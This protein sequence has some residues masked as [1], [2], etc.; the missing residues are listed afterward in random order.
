ALDRIAARLAAPFVAGEIGG[1]LLGGE[2]LEGDDRAGEAM[3]G[4][5][6]AVDQGDRAKDAVAAARQQFQALA[7]LFFTFRLGEN[8]A[9][10]G[11][12]DVGGE[13]QR[14]W[15]GGRRRLR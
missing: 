7:A 8:P 11:D 3:A 15:R 14:A 4:L 2:A 1:D 10:G 13:G 12:D 9:P 5:A 6:V